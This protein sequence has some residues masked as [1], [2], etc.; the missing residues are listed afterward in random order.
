[1]DIATIL[2]LI[3]KGMGVISTL[4]TVGQDALPAVKVVTDLV[5]G[6]AM[7]F[8]DPSWTVPGQY[9]IEQAQPLPASILGVIP[10][11]TTGGR[12]G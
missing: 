1:M 3:M 6:D 2:D 11:V 7:T 12:K 9:C 8:L 4:I 10:K 5:T